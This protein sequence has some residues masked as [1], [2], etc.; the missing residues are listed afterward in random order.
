MAVRKL[1]ERITSPAG[2]YET[3][4]GKIICGICINDC[5]LMGMLHTLPEH[6]GKGYARLVVNQTMKSFATEFGAVP[7]SAVEIRN[8]QSVAFHES[9][10][11]T[12]SHFADFIK[13]V[14]QT[15]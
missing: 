13:Y 11:M 2:L 4:T 14:P 3:E 7:C 10:G 12:C 15:W 1:L 6:R 9:L 5:G 8:T